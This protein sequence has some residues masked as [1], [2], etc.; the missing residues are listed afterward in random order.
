[1]ARS[2]TSKWFA[3][4]DVQKKWWS[5]GGFSAANAVL[6]DPSFKDQTAAFAPQFLEAMGR[7]QDFWQEPAYAQ[8][9]QA[10]EKRA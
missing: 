2:N 1:M 3:Q 9:L 6:N 7:V 10:M 4:P 5:L 8:L